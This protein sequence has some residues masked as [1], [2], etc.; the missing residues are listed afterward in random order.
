MTAGDAVDRNGGPGCGNVTSARDLRSGHRFATGSD[1]VFGTRVY[2]HLGSSA[3]DDTRTVNTSSS[4]AEH[5]RAHALGISDH[6]PGFTG[7]EGLSREVIAVVT[8]LYSTAPGADM[9]TI[10]PPR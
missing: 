6:F 5:E 1:G 2:V 7:D 10:C 9:S 3:C 8:L 4:V